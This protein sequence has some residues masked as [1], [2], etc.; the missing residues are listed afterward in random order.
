MGVLIL[1]T[2]INPGTFINQYGRFHIIIALCCSL[3]ILQLQLY[4]WK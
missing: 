2:L 3:H 4:S 1:L